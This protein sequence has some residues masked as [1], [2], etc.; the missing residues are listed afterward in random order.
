M[1]SWF[2]SKSTPFTPPALLPANKGLGTSARIAFA[3]GERTWEESADLLDLLAA[4]LQDEKQSARRHAKALELPSGFILQPQMIGF[5]PVHHNGVR[6]TTTI[7][8]NHPRVFPAGLFEYQHAHGAT[9]PEAVTDGFQAWAQGDLPA[10]LDALEEK[11]RVC[12]CLEMAITPPDGAPGARCVRRVI[13][14]PPGRVLVRPRDEMPDNEGTGHPF[15]PCCLFTNSL[16]AFRELLETDRTCGIRLY[17]TRS[18]S[19]ESLADCRVNGEDWSAGQEALLNY[20]NRW[21][22]LGFEV[23]KQFVVVQTVQTPSDAISTD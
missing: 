21:P 11:P 13:F 8:V 7:Q 3:N 17:A 5:Q 18:P 23:R 15:C 20:V 19:G 22:D 6:T 9:F 2:R 1:F 16:E 4:T 10:L 14:G 12:T